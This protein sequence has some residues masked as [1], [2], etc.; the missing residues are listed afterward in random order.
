MPNPAF[1]VKELE[2]GG[3]GVFSQDGSRIHGVCAGTFDFRDT[4]QASL[5]R[6]L[7][8]LDQ[9][10]AASHKGEEMPIRRTALSGTFQVVVDA[11]T[12]EDANKILASAFEKVPQVLGFK[13]AKV[14]R[15]TADWKE[16][17]IPL[18]TAK[19]KVFLAE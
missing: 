11:S 15:G 13:F 6:Y 8:K 10:I 3:F 14:G 4:A 19:G 5:E 2:K 17:E 1:V 7:S 16:L 18:D 12:K 9:E